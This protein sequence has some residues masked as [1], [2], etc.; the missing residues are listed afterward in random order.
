M[1]MKGK[2]CVAIAA[3]KRMGVRGHTISMDFQKIFGELP[4]SL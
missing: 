4:C 1:A 2:N 3:D